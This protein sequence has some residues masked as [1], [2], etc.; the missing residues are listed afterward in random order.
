MANI[1]RISSNVKSNDRKYIIKDG[2]VDTAVCGGITVTA[3][4][5]TVGTQTSGYYLVQANYDQSSSIKNTNT[6]NLDGYSIFIEMWMPKSNQ[7]GANVTAYV[8]DEIVYIK[9]T[10]VD[11]GWTN[12]KTNHIISCYKFISGKPIKSFRFTVGKNAW[13]NIYNIWMEKIEE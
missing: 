10:Y 11:G 8:N 5:G 3:R 1:M 6:I 4:G 13:L 9:T 12:S 2:V 7:T